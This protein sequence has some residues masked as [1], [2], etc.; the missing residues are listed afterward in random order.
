M[1]RRYFKVR[2]L[3]YEGL[4]CVEHIDTKLNS[5]DLLTKS[6]GTELYHTHRTR[7]MNLSEPAAGHKPKRVTFV[8]ARGK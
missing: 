8:V 1:D 5:A 4:V 2:E 7:L 6:L 3:S